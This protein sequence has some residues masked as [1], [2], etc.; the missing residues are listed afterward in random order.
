MQCVS[1]CDMVGVVC[2]IVGVVKLV[3]VPLPCLHGVFQLLRNPC[4]FFGIKLNKKCVLLTFSLPSFLVEE[5]L[6][7]GKIGADEPSYG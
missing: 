7:K 6:R 3:R 2:I 4:F 1:V 5:L